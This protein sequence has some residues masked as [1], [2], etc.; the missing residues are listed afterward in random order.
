MELINNKEGRS[1]RFK[2]GVRYWNNIRLQRRSLVLKSSWGS[3]CRQSQWSKS[4]EWFA[5][6]NRA[7]LPSVPKPSFFHLN[8]WPAFF[9]ALMTPPD[10]TWI[11]KMLST[12]LYYLGTGSWTSWLGSSASLLTSSSLLK[13][14]FTTRV[15]SIKTFSSFWH[16]D[17]SQFLSS[18][19]F[20]WDQA[21]RARQGY[22]RGA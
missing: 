1:Y 6:A 3:K 4:S 18:H 8:H 12:Y 9:A 20:N 22:Q 13:I 11:W 15:I 14:L 7:L 2:R 17:Q 5:V 10:Q 19:N 21:W 16:R